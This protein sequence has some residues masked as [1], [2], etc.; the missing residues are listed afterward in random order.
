MFF[1]EGQASGCRSGGFVIAAVGVASDC[2]GRRRVLQNFL[3]AADGSIVRRAVSE[4]ARRVGIVDIEPNTVEYSQ[5]RSSG[6]RKSR[7]QNLS[8]SIR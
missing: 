2:A 6:S 5:I 4:L 1:G 3:R 8:K 7:C